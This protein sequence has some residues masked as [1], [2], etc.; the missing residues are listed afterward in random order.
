MAKHN[1][2]SVRIRM[3]RQGLGDCFLLTFQQKDKDD[4]NM[5]IDCGLLQGTKNSTEIMQKVVEDVEA[6][7]TVTKKI[8][9]KEK[10]LLD[11]VVLTHEHADHISGFKQ[12][13]DVFERMHFGEVW[14]GWMDDEHHPK[15][16][17]VRERFHKQVTGLKAALA[18]MDSE[19]QPGLYET[20]S[21]LVNDFFDDE[22]LG[23]KG[24][25]EGRTPAWEYALKKSVNNPRFC[26]PGNMFTLPG[27]DDIRFYI[28][29]PSENFEDFSKVNPSEEDTY[30]SEGSG[31]ALAD[32]FFAAVAGAGDLFDAELRQ[33]FENHL[34]V[35]AEKEAKEH[36]FFKAHYGFDEDDPGKW[37]RINDDWL[38]MAGSLALNLDSYTNNT[39]LAFAIEFIS[40]KKVLLFPGDA[41]FS[42]WLSWQG[43]SWKIPDEHGVEKEV[44]AEH[45]LNRTVFYKVGHHGSHNATLKKHGLEM[46]SSP[47][48]M[49]MIPVDRAQAE[50]KTS[51]TNP[52]GWEM[53]E[54]NLFNRLQERARGR[55]LLADEK[56]RQN[57]EARCQDKTFL[58]K[59]EFKGTFVRNPEESTNAEPLAID[60][61]ITG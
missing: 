56:D 3:Y 6:T 24:G 38:T 8:D 31:F 35:D 9:E 54:K 25:K 15:Y 22:V 45:L 43:L 36:D 21:S 23:V 42:N 4:F 28:L 2:V 47:E 57:L 16:K 14:A 58:K 40:S 55:V 49:A 37:R 48:L 18:R 46:M 11:V 52:K 20:V 53:P 34:R 50:S 12:A 41:Q 61:T 59:V 27:L 13:Q 19:K 7:L 26:S 30:R 51:K 10:K 60:L 44:K 33:P 17:A 32:S 5:M 29:G 1:K 39:C